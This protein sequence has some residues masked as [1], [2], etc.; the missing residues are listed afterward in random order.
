MTVN[1]NDRMLCI[2]KTPPFVKEI[3]DLLY[4]F[5]AVPE[6]KNC[7]SAPPHPPVA[8]CKNTVFALLRKLFDLLTLSEKLY[9]ILHPVKKT[10][11]ISSAI[12]K[13]T[14]HVFE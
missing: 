9:L 1:S 5:T 4:G 10:D 12:L 8:P 7:I 11:S 14:A 6:C 3:S 2:V 13:K